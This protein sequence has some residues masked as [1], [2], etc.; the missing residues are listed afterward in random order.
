MY[1]HLMRKTEMERAGYRQRPRCAYAPEQGHV[2][3]GDTEQPSRIRSNYPKIWLFRPHLQN[4]RVP[5]T[6]W[7]TRRDLGT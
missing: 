6:G 7:I 5:T 1:T 4:Y 3:A 2:S